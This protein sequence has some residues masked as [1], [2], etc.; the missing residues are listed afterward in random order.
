MKATINYL[1]KRLLI[2]LIIYVSLVLLVS[3]NFF[4]FKNIY[5][6]HFIKLGNIVFSNFAGEGI[7]DF[8]DGFAADKKKYNLY[9]CM[10]TLISK[11]QKK[12]AREEAL[13]RGDNKLTYNPARFS[14]NSWNHF[15]ELLLFFVALIISLPIALKHRLVTFVFG[16]L[17]IHIFFYVKIWTSINLNY[18]RFYDQFQVGWSNDFLVNLLNYFRLVVMSPFFCM[19]FIT[20]ITLFLSFRYWNIKRH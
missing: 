20:L 15:G 6:N 10:I 11:P 7:V 14:L 3:S 5:H 16:Y 12:K 2:F 9:D 4:N 18:S 17:L 19:V 13:K 1:I 8:K